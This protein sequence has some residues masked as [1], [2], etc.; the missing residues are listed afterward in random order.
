[1]LVN[2]V[3]SAVASF[4]FPQT[5]SQPLA[6]GVHVAG[7]HAAVGYGVDDTL[8]QSSVALQE[9]GVYVFPFK[10]VPTRPP[11]RHVE[12]PTM[13]EPAQ[14]PLPSHVVPAGQVT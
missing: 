1:M 10:H 6:V 9:V 2:F 13:H 5:V 4:L 12:L 7:L 3:W 8:T 11:A 14:R